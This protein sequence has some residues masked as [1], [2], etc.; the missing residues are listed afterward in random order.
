MRRP[1]LGSPSSGTE[2]APLVPSVAG[3]AEARRRNASVEETSQGPPRIRQRGCHKGQRW[4]KRAA[5][6]GRGEIRREAEEVR[7]GAPTPSRPVEGGGAPMSSR[8]STGSKS[9]RRHCQWGLPPIPPAWT[10]V[11]RPQGVPAESARGT[12]G[13][14]QGSSWR[15]LGAAGQRGARQLAAAHPESQAHAHQRAGP[16]PRP[17]TVFWLEMLDLPPPMLPPLPPPPPPPPQAGVRPAGC[18]TSALPLPGAARHHSRPPVNPRR[19]QKALR[20]R[21]RLPREQP[22]V[23]QPSP[24][25]SP[26]PS[27]RRLPRRLWRGHGCVAS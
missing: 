16:R 5:V 20:R 13:V 7:G 19:R 9:T 25:H 8:P 3:P 21:R 14:K 12:W 27:R 18:A 4:R 2:E 11:K 6:P 10:P 22:L 26:S 1:P 23:R 17:P 15:R 24:P